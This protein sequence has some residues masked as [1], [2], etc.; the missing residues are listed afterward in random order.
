MDAFLIAIIIVLI[1][2]LLLFLR[3]RYIKIKS[4]GDGKTYMV[5]DYKDSSRAAEYLAK[6][7]ENMGVFIR[8]LKIKYGRDHVMVNSIANNYNPDVLVEHIPNF[9]EPHIAFTRNKGDEIYVC[10]RDLHGNLEDFNTVMFVT[11][12]ELAHISIEPFGHPEEFWIAFKWILREAIYV[13]IYEPIN[14]FTNPT[15]Y[16]NVFIDYTPLFDKA[17]EKY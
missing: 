1:I 12:H 6:I 5:L 7:N 4:Q 9:R 14:Y 10:L 11:L 15:R 16:H 3:P 17:I 2:L 13:D 8:Q